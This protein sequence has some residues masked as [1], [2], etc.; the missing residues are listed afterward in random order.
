MKSMTGYGRAAV[1]VASLHVVVEAATVNRK[2]LDVAISLPREWQVL[3]PQI[4][5]AIRDHIHRGR[6]NL[7]VAVEAAGGS[8]GALIDARVVENTL[9]ELAEV[10]QKTG[11]FF[12]PDARLIL[13]IATA[14]RNRSALPEAEAVNG[15]VMQ[16]VR[17]AITDLAGMR[18]REGA[19]L[20]QDLAHRREQLRGWLGEIRE[21]ARRVVPNYR[22]MLF[23]R[24]RQSGLELDLDDDRVLKEIAL[25]ADRCDI[26]EELTRLESHLEQFGEFLEV[27]EPVGRK[28]EFLLQEVGREFNTIGSKASDSTVSRLVIDCKNEIERVREQVLNIE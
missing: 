8:T 2:N 19:S 23:K 5:E 3:E 24:L 22:E 1:D 15:P 28:I 21:A 14:S 18:E 9:R 20:K 4:I 7:S 25:F 26:S 13:D 12:Q 6:I 27:T 17:E 10:C 16:A 11:A